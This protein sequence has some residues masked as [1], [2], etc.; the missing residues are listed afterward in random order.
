MFSISFLDCQPISIWSLISSAKNTAEIDIKTLD[1]S[2]LIRENV[3]SSY[4]SGKSSLCAQDIENLK[5]WSVDN[6][7]LSK[8]N[9]LTEEGEQELMGIANRLQKA[10]PSLLRDLKNGNHKLSSAKGSIEENT[11]TFVKG[12]HERLTTEKTND[13]II[14]SYYQTKT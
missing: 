14:V 4:M 10:F 9:F 6:K 1:E 13:N 8:I 11:N 2:L 7:M 12:F 5:N 3:I